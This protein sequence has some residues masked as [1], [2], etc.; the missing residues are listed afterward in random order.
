MLLHVALE[1]LTLC[2]LDREEVQ[3]GS[4]FTDLDRAHNVGMLHALAV[5][6]LSDEASHRRLVLA[7]F[8]S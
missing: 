8:L 4:R 3:P 1:Q 5:L 7:E 6:R 2:P